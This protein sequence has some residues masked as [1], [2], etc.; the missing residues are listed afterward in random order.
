MFTIILLPLG[1]FPTLARHHFRRNISFWKL[2]SN[3]L[4]RG[5]ITILF[6]L[7]P[8]GLVLAQYIQDFSVPEV[9]FPSFLYPSMLMMLVGDGSGG[10]TLC[11]ETVYRLFDDFF[12]L[13]SDL[14][15]GGCIGADEEERGY[16]ELYRLQN[17]PLTNLRELY[18]Q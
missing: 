9:V 4:G 6:A 8:L 1:S 2:T 11:L 7:C 17:A 13:F 14:Q 10:W 3:F 18:V 12:F 15:A 5:T 16:T